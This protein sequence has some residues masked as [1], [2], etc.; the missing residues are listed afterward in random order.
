M[1][2]SKV[3]VLPEPS[4]YGKDSRKKAQPTGDD[5]PV[6]GCTSMASKGGVK[7]VVVNSAGKDGDS[8]CG[9]E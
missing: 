9:G 4:R 3:S 6:F 5:Q 1:M 7:E 2:I 8:A